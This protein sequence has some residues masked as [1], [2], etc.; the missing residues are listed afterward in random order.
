MIVVI[1][2]ITCSRSLLTF[3]FT[4]SRSIPAMAADGAT[5]ANVG[6]NKQLAYT[7][8]PNKG[9]DIE[10]TA[11]V[12]NFEMS[13]IAINGIKLNLASVQRICKRNR[14]F[15]PHLIL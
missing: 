6:S 10:I 9:A 13:G 3:S 4:Q 1:Y 12:K 8:L 5:V 14:L 11:D 15:M 2:R 7:I